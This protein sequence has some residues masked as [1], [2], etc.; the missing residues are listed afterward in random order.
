MDDMEVTM[1]R[2]LSDEYSLRSE[3]NDM[4][5]VPADVKMFQDMQKHGGFS[6]THETGHTTPGHIVGKP[7]HESPEQHH[8]QLPS[9]IPTTRASQFQEAVLKVHSIL[10][11]LIV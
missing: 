10:P 1:K 8:R 3:D 7:I 9:G 2:R 4:E 5:D 11:N 6:P